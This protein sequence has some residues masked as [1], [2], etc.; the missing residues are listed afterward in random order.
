MHNSY[1]LTAGLL[2]QVFNLD[3]FAISRELWKLVT[4]HCFL[5][6]DWLL[7]IPSGCP[8]KLLI[9][10]NSPNSIHSVRFLVEI[11]MHRLGPALRWVPLRQQAGPSTRVGVSGGPSLPTSTPELCLET[12]E[13]THQPVDKIFKLQRFPNV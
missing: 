7:A 12:I 2:S 9:Q 10:N 13:S 3:R 11:I 8:G 1:R 5:V 4:G 6:P